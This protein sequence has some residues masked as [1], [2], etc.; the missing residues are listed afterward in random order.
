MK[1]IVRKS[2]SVVIWGTDDND[3]IVKVV[4]NNL[5]IND[6][7]IATDVNE[8]EYDLIED[9]SITLIQPFFV[10]YVTYTK[11]WGAIIRLFTSSGKFNYTEEYNIWN[12]KTHNCLSVIKD[13]YFAKSENPIY[14]KEEREEFLKYSGYC[15][16]L[17]NIQYLSPTFEYPCPPDELFPFYPQCSE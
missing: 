17:G 8:S 16:L 4:D 1:V 12:L 2:D 13:E 14:S 7:V 3:A 6:Q 5:V 15:S 10:G 11:T 9:N